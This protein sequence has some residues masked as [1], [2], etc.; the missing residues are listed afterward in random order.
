MW[1]DG[2]EHT[3]RN[4]VL[5][6]L[7]PVAEA[8]LRRHKVDAADISRYL[9]VMEARCRTAAAARA[10]S[11]RRGTRCATAPRP[12]ERANALVAAT[13]QRQQTDRPVSEWE[14][15]RLDEAKV[16]SKNYLSVSSTT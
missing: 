6:R 3:A 7:L 8:G 9:G 2:E 5:D 15:A 16:T 11:W 10:G 4:L 13:V 12:A 1:L 14:R